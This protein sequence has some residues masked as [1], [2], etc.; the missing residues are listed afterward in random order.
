MIRS[1][2]SRALLIALPG[3]LLAGFGLVH[4]HRINA[5]T[6]AWWANLHI[7]LLPVFPLLA[8]AQWHL[9][10]P[11][12][13]PVRWLGRLAA[14]GFA[15]FYTGL[16]AVAGIAVGTVVDAQHGSSPAVGRLFVV[17]DALG[18]VGAWG[19]LVASVLIVVAI[20]PHAGWRV[21]PGAVLL[22]AASVSFLDSHLFWPRGVF[23]M[24]GVAVGM[25]LLSYA[26][27]PP[28]TPPASVEPR[29]VHRRA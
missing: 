26:G 12:P 16:D 20:A 25:F 7:I 27:P 9:L 6:A 13:P 22:L 14:Y 5:D 28:S 17:G 1:P 2:W 4:P 8:A 29:P 3:L 23:T 21:V 24:V 19:F 11:A 15:T 18:Y 10:T